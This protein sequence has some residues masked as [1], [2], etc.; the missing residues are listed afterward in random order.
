MTTM[1][2]E[3]TIAATRARLASLRADGKRVALVPTMGALH[4]GHLAL[5]DAAREAA[6][7]VVISI[8]VNPLQ[9]GPNE[10]L[11]RYPRT[12]DA[13]VAALRERGADLIFAPSAAE[14]YGDAQDRTTVVPRGFAGLFEGAIR[15]GH[16]A[17]VLTVVAKL[18]N[19]VQP[20]V[21]V[22]GRKDLQQ[23]ALVRA[24]VADLDFPIEIV[25]YETVREADGLALSSR[26][27]YLDAEQRVLATRLREA[28]A[29]AKLAFA[30]GVHEP[31]AIAAAGREVLMRSPVLPVDYLAVVRERDFST[32]ERASAG[33]A[34]VGAVRVGTTRLLDN[35][36]L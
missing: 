6:D 16:F 7:V 17:G 3:H 18:F 23:L 33:D 25:G 9:F 15:P 4:A 1:H 11:A 31:E 29:T 20:D 13:D 27:R 14:M 34:I 28:L 35:I 19:I 2:I 21:A 5:V 24:M 12:L 26:N 8:F 32:P 36:Q 30:R 22:F 10:D